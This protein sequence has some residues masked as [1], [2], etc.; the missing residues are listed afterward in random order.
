GALRDGTRLVVAL[1]AMGALA[2]RSV[3]VPEAAKLFE[4]LAQLRVV[5][6]TVRPLEH[7]EAAVIGG[8]LHLG[9]D[10][11][12]DNGW[13]NALHDIGEA[14]NLRRLNMNGIGQHGRCSRGDGTKADCPGDGQ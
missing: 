8:R 5:R 14:R 9:L 12:A 10:L 7:A 4:E 11:D 2:A 13:R 1:L 6:Q 3:L